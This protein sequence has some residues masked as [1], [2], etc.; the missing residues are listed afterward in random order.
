M[1]KIILGIIIFIIVFVYFIFPF[2]IIPDF[3]PLFG[4]IDDL[5]VLIAGVFTFLRV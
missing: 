1:N 4:W 3:I 2:D 5:L